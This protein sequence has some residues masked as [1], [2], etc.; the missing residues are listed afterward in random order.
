[1]TDLI[2]S[3]NSFH[4]TLFLTPLGWIFVLAVNIVGFRRAELSRIKD[5]VFSQVEEL[6]VDIKD[7]ISE[8]S[9]TENSLDD[10]LA[11]RITLLEL[12]VNQFVR[13]S[14][15]ELL[16]S[17]SISEMRD[18]PFQWLNETGNFER[19]ISDF[20]Y[21][22]L[23]EIEKKYSKW[24]FERWWQSAFRIIKDNWKSIAI[25]VM[26]LLFSLYLF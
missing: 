19:M 17:E 20:E 8:R 21:K 7:K 16:S 26:C 18:K 23:E 5:K 22:I 15:F 12:R 14:G 25:V 9:C 4:P 6:F 1:M 24:L 2:T 11:P 13:K 10:L 3:S